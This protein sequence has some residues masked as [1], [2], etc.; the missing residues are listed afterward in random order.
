[1]KTLKNPKT[2]SRFEDFHA[3]RVI[4]RLI[5]RIKIH[6]KKTLK[7][8]VDAEL[9]AVPQYVTWMERMDF[10]NPEKSKINRCCGLYMLF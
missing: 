2:R 1:M 6:C 7:T 3:I 4:L 5:F 9:G 10:G 8:S